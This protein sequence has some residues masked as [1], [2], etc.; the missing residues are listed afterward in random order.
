MFKKML[1]YVQKPADTKKYTN[2]LQFIILKM[3]YSIYEIN[4]EDIERNIRSVLR[5][6]D[7]NFMR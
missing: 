6:I 2:K 4:I 1:G 7:L 3:V 5:D